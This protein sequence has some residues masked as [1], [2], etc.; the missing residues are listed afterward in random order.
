MLAV[1]DGGR[2]APGLTGHISRHCI[3]RPANCTG[4]APPDEDAC[5]NTTN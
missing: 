5:N 1:R 3:I 2:Q 4:A